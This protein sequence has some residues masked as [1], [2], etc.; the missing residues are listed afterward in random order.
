[1]EKGHA[2]RNT[3][4][5]LTIVRH[6]RTSYNNRE[7]TQGQLDVPLDEVGIKQARDAGNA[8][9]GEQFDCVY[10]SDLSRTIQTATEIIQLNKN[11]SNQR[12]IIKRDILLRERGYGIMEDKPISDLKDAAKKAG[13]SG[14]GG[15]NHTYQKVEKVMSRS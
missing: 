5:F 3:T 11:S 2:N 13:F 12:L 7:I 6:G 8:L 9:K 1:M 4:L 15:V 14:A 10:T